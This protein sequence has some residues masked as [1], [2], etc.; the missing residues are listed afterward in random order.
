[1]AA[2]TIT[3]SGQ[4]FNKA[5]RLAGRRMVTKSLVFDYPNIDG[6]EKCDLGLRGRVM[7]Y[8]AEMRASTMALLDA[9]I[10]AVEELVQYD[11][12]T[13]TEA[14]TYANCELTDF[15]VISRA[16]CEG[17]QYAARVALVFTQ[18]RF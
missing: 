17:G 10:A 2:G 9:A 8:T 1:M 18:L 14:G 6:V 13:M 15:Q 4:T 11:A 7:P 12:A 5:V 3:W 16:R